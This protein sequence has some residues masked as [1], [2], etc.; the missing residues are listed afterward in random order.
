MKSIMASDSAD[1][2]CRLLVNML[3]IKEVGLHDLVN[4]ATI[5]LFSP[6]SAESI[7]KGFIL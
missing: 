7:F 5:S 4:C 6:H 1:T 2:L 3:N